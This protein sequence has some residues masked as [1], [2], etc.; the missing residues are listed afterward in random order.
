MNEGDNTQRVLWFTNN[1]I[2]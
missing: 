2:N 1:G